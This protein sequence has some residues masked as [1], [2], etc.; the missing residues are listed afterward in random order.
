MYLEKFEEIHL[1]EGQIPE[2]PLDLL[3]PG[4]EQNHESF[5]VGKQDIEKVVEHDYVVVPLFDNP[6]RQELEKIAKRLYLIAEKCDIN[7]KNKLN[8]KYPDNFIYVIR[9]TKVGLAIL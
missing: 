8:K 3:N 6:G 2:F 1:N 7:F 4:V 9:G 5:I